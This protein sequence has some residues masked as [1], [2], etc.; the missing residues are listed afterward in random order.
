SVSHLV[1]SGSPFIGRKGV[2]HIQDG[3][4]AIK[5]ASLARGPFT[6][7]GGN[8]KRIDQSV[9]RGVKVTE[10]F[11]CDCP[12]GLARCCAIKNEDL[13]SYAS[14]HAGIAPE[15]KKP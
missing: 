10:A 7:L 5:R 9:G 12:S 3:T 2:N 13:H 4:R 1:P 14:N 8:F 6:E 11:H 15:S